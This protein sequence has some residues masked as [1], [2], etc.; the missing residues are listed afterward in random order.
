MRY[1]KN[2]NND[3]L[4]LQENQTIPVGFEEISQEEVIAITVHEISLEEK[5]AIKWEELKEERRKQKEKGFIYNDIRFD[6]NEEAQTNIV[7]AACKALSASLAGE[8]IQILWTT[9]DNDV[10]ILKNDDII[11]LQSKMVY[12]GANIQAYITLLRTEKDNAQSDEELNNIKW[13]Y[14]ENIDY[15]SPNIYNEVKEVNE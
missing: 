7:N 12:E 14:D 9:F 11:G 2:E 1:F 5:K 10:V 8:E 6:G 15:L 13:L 3:I 4:S